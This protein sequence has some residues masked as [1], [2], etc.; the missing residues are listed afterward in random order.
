[1]SFWEVA[2]SRP[3]RA[4][5][6]LVVVHVTGWRS[7]Q[8]GSFERFLVALADQVAKQGGETHLVFP[9]LPTSRAFLSDC[10]A[11]VHV[12][13]SPRSAWDPRFAY[14]IGHLLRAVGA[15][16]VHAHYGVDAFE[17]LLAGRA[18]GIRA[19]YFTKH[20]PPE[21]SFAA[22]LRHRLVGRQVRTM[23]AVSRATAAGLKVAGI[24]AAKIEVVYLGTDPTAYRPATSAERETARRALGVAAGHR[25]VLTTSHLRPGKG[26]ELLPPLAAKLADDPGEVVVLAAGDGPLRD[27]VADDAAARG[28]DGN[29]FRLLGV[30]ED[31]PML[32]AAADVFVLPTSASYGFREGFGLSVLE[33][34]AAGL[35]VVATDVAD[36]SALLGGVARI[37]RPDDLD[38]LADACRTLLKD[39]SSARMFGAAGRR[40]VSERLSVECSAGAYLAHYLEVS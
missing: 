26:V 16:H 24:P 36:I 15:T 12:L 13:P 5:T 28:I 23:F 39:P 35:P 9:A 1:M 29:V 3:A 11:R 33:A 22:G 20:N 32:L 7:Q 19:R 10:R 14:R 27:A 18:L 21:P 17:A 2:M 30:R 6:R 31:I 37:V 34:L 25:V 38:A 8:Y 4:A 40:L